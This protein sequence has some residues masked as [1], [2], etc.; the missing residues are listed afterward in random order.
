M[1]DKFTSGLGPK[2]GASAF[3]ARLECFFSSGF[4]L[5]VQFCRVLSISHKIM[6]EILRIAHH[7]PPA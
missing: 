5:Q 4:G 7:S 3:N 6:D 2:S 1:H